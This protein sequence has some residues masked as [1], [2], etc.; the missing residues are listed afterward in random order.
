MSGVIPSGIE[1]ASYLLDPFGAELA[2]LL[3]GSILVLITEHV[4]VT[5][6]DRT[7]Y[8]IGIPARSMI[9]AHAESETRVS[10]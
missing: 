8:W 5:S 7:I 1:A 4:E 3:C 9:A 6:K 10:Q 2:V